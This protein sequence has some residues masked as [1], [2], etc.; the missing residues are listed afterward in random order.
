MC[1]TARLPQ[2]QR[3]CGGRELCAAAL[4]HACSSAETP[5]PFESL[6]VGTGG[7]LI[8]IQPLSSLRQ[9]QSLSAHL[10]ILP[11]L[12]EGTE[13]EEKSKGVYLCSV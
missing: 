2:S 8:E 13:K 6:N 11:K 12:V 1:M 5:S 7:D 10:Q 3:R 4:P 9:K